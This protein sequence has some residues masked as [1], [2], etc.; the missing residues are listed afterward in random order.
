[1]PGSTMGRRGFLGL[2]G[3][4]AAA[5]FLAAC[6]GDDS[7][8]AGGGGETT[9][10]TESTTTQAA[11]LDP[12]SE[13][14]GPLRVFDW[15]GYEIKEFWGPYFDGPYGKRNPLKFSFLED[16][17]QALAKLAAGYQTDV[18]HPCIA[19][20]KDYV[21][22]GLLQ[23]WQT[24]YITGWDKINPRLYE[25]GVVDGQNYAVPWDWGFSAPV[26]RSDKVKPEK[27]SWDIFRDERY[28]GKMAFFSDG[29]AIIKVGG[30]INGVAD[31]NK[32]TS[33]EIEAAKNTMLEIRPNLRN[34]WASETDAIKDFT[35]GN[36]WVT[37]GWP[38][39]FTQIRDNK[40]MKGVPIEY[41]QPDEGRLGWVCAY[42]QHA[43]SKL[44]AIAHEMMKVAI[45]PKTSANLINLYA[46][47]AAGGG[48]E[49]LGLVTDKS[50][51][52]AFG[53]DDPTS[54]DPPKVWQEA[55]LPNRSEYVKAAEEVK[56]AS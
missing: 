43:E 26:F 37:Y 56:A 15:A 53:L 25:A 30:L 17:Q 23:P 18:I 55:W 24:D 36:V 39:T 12:M 20:V 29:V 54:L 42:I 49:T 3:G 47:G 14:E 32:M 7:D 9:S 50:K 33:D 8:D 11:A 27:N 38:G 22:A 1:M 4:V 31:P 21:D 40:K 6:G 48:E 2:G 13:A 41:M 52:K 45:S 51:I 16:D 44:P 34:F 46:Y 10:A 28:K 35:E 5:A 19:Y